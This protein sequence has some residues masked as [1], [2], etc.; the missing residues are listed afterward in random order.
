M[1]HM[2]PF[3][4][5]CD[6]GVRLTFNKP[7][8]KSIR[9]IHTSDTHLGDDPGHPRAAYGLTAVVDAVPRLGGEA[10][11]LAGDV[12]DNARVPDSV[13]EFFLEQIGRWTLLTRNIHLC[14]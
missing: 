3:R 11:L 9:L 14:I 2:L 12:F 7:V 8:R 13:L 1:Y 10:L 4:A 6:H 5:A